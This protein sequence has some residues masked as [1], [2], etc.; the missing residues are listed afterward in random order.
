[1]QT[2]ISFKDEEVLPQISRHTSTYED[3]MFVSSLFSEIYFNKL[4]ALVLLMIWQSFWLWTNICR[5]TFFASFETFIS[6]GP[7]T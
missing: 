4:F 7:R 1:M 6:L 3:K 2:L 5:Y